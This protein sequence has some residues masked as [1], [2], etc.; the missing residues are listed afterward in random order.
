[1]KTHL[2]I[3]ALV[4]L[5]LAGHA[6]TTAIPDAN[7]EQALIDLGID[8]N[9][10]NGNI[11][12]TDAEAV[13]GDLNVFNKSIADL[14]GIEAFTAITGLYCYGNLLTSL[15]LSS[16]I[17]LTHLNCK[18]NLIA[19]LDLSG[20]TALTY[21]YCKNNKLASLDVS[22]NT[23]LTY[24]LCSVN[25]LTGLDV[26]TNTLLTELYCD[27]N[28]LVNIDVSNNIL[29]DKGDLSNNNLTAIDVSSNTVLTSLFVNDNSLSSLNVSS[30][31]ALLT[32]LCYLNDLTSLDVSSNTALT[33]L[34][35]YNN[36][37]VNLNLSNNI[38]LTTLKCEY[39]NITKL[40]LS[41]NIALTDLSCHQNEL[42]ALNVKNGTNTIITSFSANNNPNLLCIQVDDVSYSSTNWTA[43]G[44]ASFS[45][46]CAYTTAIPDANFEQAL[47]DLGIDTNGLNGNILNTDAVAVTGTLEVSSKNITDLTGIEAF[48]AVTSLAS[49]FNQLTSLD[50]SSSN[51]SLKSLS[52]FNND[53]TNINLSNCTV[54]KS[55]NLGE[56]QLTSLDISNNTALT[57]LVI[58]NNE[59]T[60]LDVSGHSALVYLGINNNNLNSLDV[61]ANTALTDLYIW[62]NPI[63]SLDVTNNINL[64]KLY[65]TSNGLSSLD[66][67][68]N[69]A[70]TELYCG[71]NSLTILDLSNNTLLTKLNCYSNQLTSLNLTNNPLL[72]DVTCNNNLLTSLDVTNNL[73]LTGLTCRYNDLTNLNITN[74]IAL[75]N[76]DCGG[77]PLGTIDISNN[78]ALTILHSYD[79]QLTSL[80]VSNNA[81][82]TW[83]KCSQN[84]LTSLDV[85]N[86]VELLTLQ[87]NENVLASLDLSNN[88]KLVS[89]DGYSNQL[90]N[91][92]FS[93]S[94]VDLYGLGVNDNLLTTLD[95]SQFPT[96]AYLDCSNNQLKS[97]NAKTGNNVNFTTFI[98]SSN[99]NLLCIEVDDAA[100]STTNWTD[101][102]AG[103]SFSTDC[104]YDDDG[105]GVSNTQEVAD[106]TD[107]NDGCDY[108]LASQVIANVTTAWNNLDC[109]GDGVTNGVEITDA[110]D[111]KDGC[112]Y[113]V[114]NQLIGNVTAAWNSLDC[115]GDGVTNGIEITDATNPEDGCSYIAVNQVIANVTTAWNDLDCDG[116]GVTNGIEIADGTD[117]ELGCSYLISSQIVANV[118]PAWNSLDCDCDGTTNGDEVINGMDVLLT[119]PTSATTQSFCLEDSPTVLQ[120]AA[121]GTNINWY[122]DATGGSVLATTVALTNATYYVSQI[123]GSCESDR[124]A[125][126]VTVYNPSIPTGVGTQNFCLSNNP[127][128]AQLTAT[129]S[130]IQWYAV[131]TGGTALA[132]TVALTDATTYF[133]SQTIGSCES[134]R[135]EVTVAISNVTV[136]PTGSAAQSFCINDNPT[137]AQLVATG[138]GVQWYAAATG[139]TALASTVTLTDGTTYYASQTVGSCESDRFEVTVTISNVTVPTGSAAQSFCSN[140]NP[141]VA[142][143][144]ATGT[145]IQWY[146]AT[147]GGTALA[148]TVALTNATTYFASQTVGSCESD[149]FEVTV[150]ISNVAVPTGSTA[151]SFCS[152]DNPTVAQLAATGTGIQWYAATTGGT[153]LASTDALTDGTTYYASQTVGSCES[154][155]FEVTV[156]ISNVAVPTGSAAQSF[157]SNNNPTVAQLAATGT[158]VQ[159]YAVTTGGTALA[160]TDVLTDGTTYYASQSIGSCESNRFEVT[161]SIESP[162]FPTGETTQAFC[163]QNNPTVADLDIAGTNVQ[164]YESM[165]GGSPLSN[166]A[167]LISTDYFASQTIDNCESERFQVSVTLDNSTCETV[168]GLN[169]W[170][171]SDITIYPTPTTGDVYINLGEQY[172]DVRLIIRNIEGSI[173]EDSNYYLTNEIKAQIKGSKGVYLIQLIPKTGSMLTYRVIKK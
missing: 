90:T 172:T 33:R 35:L 137:V 26:S 7:F 67:S 86:N 138:T 142:Q 37:V 148:T 68:N 121:T 23:E 31:T 109:D 28:D 135:F 155:R 34:E 144:A 146:A 56:N 119:P 6:Q 100:Y 158:G 72:T 125:V 129:G 173:I 24:L 55:L 133:A 105:D 79:N 92:T 95:L 116:D 110:T 153:A 21:L 117:F 66:V 113:L 152:N 151:Q 149:R 51:A 107:P 111:P 71:N 168:L 25:L 8:T 49:N 93:G 32:L 80:D 13:T 118:T 143:L 91:I 45:T 102:D 12:N 120:L 5:S 127:T 3:I 112:S 170:N 18:D 14:T 165:Q 19:S 123:P 161:V 57:Q 108:L 130:N 48:T 89:L 17:A 75:K 1:M 54:L 52:L 94:Y 36:S 69:T 58:S 38:A 64:I 47:I 74:N 147:T 73:L 22:A 20:N 164:W 124:L 76:L 61:S 128:I 101:I 30:N 141:T 97:L 145:G 16:N 11:L 157:C 29:L 41:N 87:C 156:A 42:V 83:I 96:L 159:W 150:A 84:N 10:L 4:L 134:D 44:G 132:T 114:A 163:D 126:T 115:D 43:I 39:N 77:N 122:A 106:T 65:C 167:E 60:S 103:A 9:G 85:S 154:D 15:N 59:L 40:N 139:G 78:T 104:Q 27:N 99:P 162:A 62:S 166:E 50:L 171:K 2:L 160:S 70:L 88:P 131:T 98:A 136:V 81:D 46:D 169:Q 63:T 140:D 82:L 53:L